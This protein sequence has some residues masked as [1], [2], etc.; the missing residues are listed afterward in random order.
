VRRD[1][2]V[3]LSLATL[4]FIGVWSDLLPFL[5]LSDR[6]PIGALPCWNDFAAV[7]LNVAGLAAIFTV[8]GTVARRGAPWLRKAAG[9]ALIASLAVPANALRMHFRTWPEVWYEGL[10]PTAGPLVL[11]A[12]GLAGLIVVLRWRERVVSGVLAA[13]TIM[14]P[15]VLVTA[16]QGVW[17]IAQA[18]GRM[19]C[20]SATGLADPI[21]GAATRRVLW[22]VYD[23]LDFATPFEKRP[24][25]LRL[26]N[27]DQ[28]VAE[29]LSATAAAPPGASTERSMPSFLSGARVLDATLV[30]R[31]QLMLQFEGR[32]ARTTWTSADTLLPKVRAL[33][34]NAGIAG[35][36]LPYCALVGDS[37][38]ACSAEPCVTCGRLTGVFGSTFSDSLWYQVAE[39][40]PRYGPRRHLGAYQATQKSALALA[41]D[42]SI[43]FALFH[44]PVPHA[45]TIYDQRRGDFAIG[46]VA[47][48]GYL[49]N[50]AL[51][52]RSLGEIRRAVADAGLSDRTTVIVFGDHGRRDPPGSQQVAD[53]RVPF[54][55]KLPGESRGVQ[56]NSPVEVIRVHD[57][58]LEVLAGRL[59]TLDSIFEWLS[60]RP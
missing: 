14:F 50:L 9:L 35:F 54:I 10:G 56:V 55:V 42:P 22:V 21:P 32:A 45:P 19:Q 15:L 29:S 24:A 53:P 26:P 23:E 16:A 33:G 7:L 43:G 5:Y 6:F 44:L 8:A 25:G 34:T 57:L 52:D 13:L 4:W 49:Q 59:Q 48:D 17:A 28:L 39:L 30:G 38:T 2:V 36:F 47:G 12:I 27:F 41:A 18:G 11:G 3:S 1:I 31:N 58:T 20:G 46:R 60:T 51:A 37:V 40:A